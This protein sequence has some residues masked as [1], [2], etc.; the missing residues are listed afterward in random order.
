MKTIS[1]FG[2]RPKELCGYYR[3]CY[4]S[5]VNEFEKLLQSHLDSNK[6]SI[7]TNG[8]QGISQ[9]AFWTANRLKKSTDINNT[10]CIPYY[11]F[12]KPWKKS[13]LFSQREYDLMEAKADKIIE[14]LTDIIPD[15]VPEMITALNECNKAMINKSDLIIAVYPDSSVWRLP[16]QGSVPDAMRYAALTYKPLL[17]IIPEISSNALRIKDTKFYC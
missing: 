5:F 11:S 1:I 7:L 15:S 9:L 8:E 13:G 12:H 4:T 2:P 6:T 17:H 14:P 16:N 3:N 10:L